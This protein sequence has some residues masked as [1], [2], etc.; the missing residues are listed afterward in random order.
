MDMIFPQFADAATFWMVS[1]GSPVITGSSEQVA[2][3][4]PALVAP[5]T[6]IAGAIVVFLDP[7]GLLRWSRGRNS[8]EAEEIIQRFPFFAILHQSTCLFILFTWDFCSLSFWFIH[9]S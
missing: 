8:T 3:A 9:N 7:T 2:P 1:A 4:V 5:D 6:S